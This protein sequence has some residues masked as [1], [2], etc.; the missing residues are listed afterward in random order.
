MS[1]PNSK[2]KTQNPF[3]NQNQNQNQKI[4]TK[5]NK[6]MI[7]QYK[8]SDK[9]TSEIESKLKSL[10]LAYKTE[11]DKNVESPILVD[12]KNRIKGKQQILAHLQ[13]LEGEL[14]QWYYCNC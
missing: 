1:L 13:A 14:H 7:L 4:N 8:K 9:T 12:G 6:N 5:S 11:K 10:T 3:K 2:Y